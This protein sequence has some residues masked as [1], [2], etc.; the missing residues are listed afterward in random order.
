MSKNKA[1]SKLSKK[2]LEVRQQLCK[3]HPDWKEGDFLLSDDNNLLKVGKVADDGL[4][5]L[6]LW[7]D[8]EWSK[9]GTIHIRE[10]LG[11][12]YIK[13]PITHESQ[14]DAWREETLKKSIEYK[15]FTLKAKIIGGIENEK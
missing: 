3:I 15:D 2:A 6:N 10:L 7:N 8:G 13:L 14:F 9:Y 4:E 5:L 12:R 1:V 11:R